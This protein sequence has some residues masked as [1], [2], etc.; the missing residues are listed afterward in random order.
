[1]PG[2]LPAP[3]LKNET[4]EEG[5]AEQKVPN[6]ESL[7]NE[8]MS[9]RCLLFTADAATAE[10][11][12]QVLAG[13]GVEGEH[14]SEG[15]S[16]VEKVTNQPFQ[17]VIID[18]DAQPEAGLLL[19]TARERKA[20][21]R[22]LTLAIVSDDASVP[23]ALQ[24]GAN[25][26][27]RK[28]ILINQVNDTLTTARDLL[29]AKQESAAAAAA[30]AAASSASASSMVAPVSSL[31]ASEKTLRAGEFLQPSGTIPGA[32][33]VTDS[34]V[35]HDADPSA[36]PVDALKDLEPVASSVGA[37]EP[38][39]EKPAALPPPAPGETRGLQW[40]LNARAGVAPQVPAQ[41]APPPPRPAPAKPELLGFDQTP[42]SSDHQSA[43]VSDDTAWAPTPAPRSALP[44]PKQDPEH[45]Q[46]AEAK[47]FAYIS[48]EEEKPE[49][50]PRRSFKL[51]GPIVAALALAA[52]AVVAAPQAPW[53]PQVLALL[54]H[55]QRSLHAW[56]NPQPVTTA[57]APQ[58]HESF[59]RAGDEYKLPVAET[60]PDATTDPSQIH[61]VPVVD[62]TKKPNTTANPDQ[63]A[64][65]D[66]SNANPTDPA[67]TP[68]QSQPDPAAGNPAQPNQ[69]PVQQNPPPDNPS[70]PQ[71]APPATQ[72]SPTVTTPAATQPA[73]EPPHSETRTEITPPPIAAQPAPR[74]SPPHTA[75]APA[76]VPSSLKSQMASM[77]PEAS[78]NKPPEAAMQAIEP[79][80][81]SEA[82]ERALL[83][84][85]PAIVYPANAKGQQGT[86]TLQ[87][88]IGRDG[89]V[90]DA[91][92][93]QGSLAFA[94]TA[95]DGVK[96][97]KFK[98][99]SM[100]GR[101][102]SVQATMTLAFKP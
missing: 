50:K 81:V 77:T 74:P 52:C 95:I 11:I 60:I 92:F 31:E 3:S 61:V 41:S 87:V 24:A 30:G 13:L 63:S 29:R 69:T 102:V 48:G 89:S 22:P 17:I 14:C 9:L 86:V 33:F 91:K 94:R 16:A 28:P 12:C 88:L 57:P 85:Q 42:S 19:T 32:H 101:P 71:S 10:P 44:T 67:Q 43:T 39:D 56:L 26:I 27:L 64:V 68:A 7:E 66:P 82:A 62:P 73:V 58:S 79:V 93:M 53:H 35:H 76:N 96:L 80:A 2:L 34:E 51:K 84:D 21:T 54:G 38:R 100:N 46:K 55:G 15:V 6:K 70:A 37:P 78:G 8:R 20:S 36:E 65:Q 98:P 25:S 23:K 72:S 97:W 4:S 90:Q 59:G 40:Y 18:W 49:E 45:E 75:A 5:R 83:S 47:L 1:L 99:Y